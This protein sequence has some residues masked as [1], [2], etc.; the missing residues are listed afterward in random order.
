MSFLLVGDR[1]S[2]Q[3]QKLCTN[4]FPLFNKGVIDVKFV[5]L[6]TYRITDMN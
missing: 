6:D 3:S 1:K 2:N 4:N 5:N